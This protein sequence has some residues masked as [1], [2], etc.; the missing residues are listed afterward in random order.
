MLFLAGVQSGSSRQGAAETIQDRDTVQ[1]LYGK[2]VSEIYRTSHDLMVTASFA[3]N[4]NLCR[5][6]ITLGLNQ[7]ITD[8]QLNAVLDELAPEDVRGEH[9]LSTFLDITCLKPVKPQNSSSNSIGE[10]TV[11]PCTECSGVSD[12]YERA[13]IT[14]YGNTN[15][16]S[17]VYIT[18][19]RPECKELEEVHH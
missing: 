9:K 3:A 6:H 8:A 12:D 17:S 19:R 4:G 11:D 1:N 15:E 5:A 18:L 14:K 7:G 13:N 16:Y 10:L 2:P